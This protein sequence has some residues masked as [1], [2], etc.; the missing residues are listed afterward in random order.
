MDHS[1]ARRKNLPRVLVFCVH[2]PDVKSVEVGAIEKNA[3]CRLRNERFCMAREALK[4]RQKRKPREPHQARLAAEDVFGASWLQLS[5]TLVSG[6]CGGSVGHSR[7]AMALAADKL[8]GER[9]GLS[10]RSP[11]ARPTRIAALPQSCPQWR[12][13]PSQTTEIRSPAS[14]CTRTVR[15]ATLTSV[16]RITTYQSV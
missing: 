1:V 16:S 2:E 11:M 13:S 4:E 14:G 5:A 15:P 10:L 7:A 12:R 6:R 9:W 3:R 8:S